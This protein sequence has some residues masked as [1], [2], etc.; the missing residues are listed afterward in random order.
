MVTPHACRDF[1][2]SGSCKI[3][4]GIDPIPL[5]V[6]LQTPDS[7]AGFKVISGGLTAVRTK[8]APTA[9]WDLSMMLQPDVLVEGAA[10][11]HACAL[12][13]AY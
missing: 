13:L 5:G 10:V 4:P 1:R 2:G 11:I 12:V 9:S 3:L 7:S 8:L 6:R